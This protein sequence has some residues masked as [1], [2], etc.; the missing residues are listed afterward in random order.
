MNALG[1]MFSIMATSAAP[2]P[3][4]TLAFD[5]PPAMVGVVY[6]GS[7]T[8]TNVDGATGAITITYDALPAGLSPGTIV[9]NGDGSY[10]LPITGTPTADGTTS[11]T[12][13]ASNGTQSA[14][15][16]SDIVVSAASATV[17]YFDP[18]RVGAFI[19]LSDANKVASSTTSGGS[20]RSVYGLKGIGSGKA[21][22]AVRID[23][24]SPTRSF[25][26]VGDAA[27]SVD[28]YIGADAHGWGYL[29]SGGSRHSGAGGAGSLAAY[30]VGDVVMVAVDAT[31]GKIWFGKNGTWV[32]DPAAGTGAVFSSL[33]GTLYP[34]VSRETNGLSVTLLVT[35][36]EIGYA[37]PTGFS[38]WS[39]V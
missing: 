36:S 33:A 30:T 27:A 10:T 8:A 28:L 26:G 12:F 29:S 37:L 32:G 35:A 39:G 23:A 17:D 11:V 5:L 6:A 14:S 19:T 2:T 7:V 13:S 38:T 31:A 9:D 15:G 4:I 3:T 1:M 24:L 21:V 18:S 22:F 20:W 16:S 25:V 34:G